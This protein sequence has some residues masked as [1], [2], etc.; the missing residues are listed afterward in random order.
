[1]SR[2]SAPRGHLVRVQGHPELVP[3]PQQQQPALR[4]VDRGL[5]DQLVEAL[6]VQLPPHLRR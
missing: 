5:A 2:V 3:H 1:M 6:R 4:A